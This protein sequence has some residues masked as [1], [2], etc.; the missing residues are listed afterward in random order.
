MIVES[1]NDV[2]V[3]N[4]R[5]FETMSLSLSIPIQ[6][7][8]ALGKRAAR[9]EISGLGYKLVQNVKHEGKC[10]TNS[11]GYSWS[12]LSSNSLNRDTLD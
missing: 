5:N 4:K 8:Q 1:K 9:N 12:Y 11:D 2:V 3:V 6:C 7:L 10:D